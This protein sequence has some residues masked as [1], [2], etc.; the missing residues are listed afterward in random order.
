MQSISRASSRRFERWFVRMP[1]FG[2]L[3]YDW[4]A[5]RPRTIGI[6]LREIAH[7]LAS[8]IE[9]GR[10][11]DV[12]TGHG[13]LLREIHNA[14]PAVE[15]FGLDISAAMLR[16]ARRNLIGPQVDLR[17]GNIRNSG[18]DSCFFNLVT[19]A[20]SLY[21]WDEPA[22]GLR[23]IYRILAPGGSSHLFE[24]DAETTGHDIRRIRTVLR[25]ETCLRRLIGPWFLR[26]AVKMGLRADDVAKMLNASPFRGSY[27]I[28]RTSL[29]GLPIWLRLTLRR[30][31]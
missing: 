7:D 9:R 2:G 18:Y 16:R 5:G 26:Y 15:L 11:L 10:L 20:G 17:Q 28:D 6:Q 4:L 30:V 12:G 14:N 21:L 22:E 27:Q 24:P 13:R 31:L 23:E 25:R 3:L 19:C 8:R 1:N 29:A